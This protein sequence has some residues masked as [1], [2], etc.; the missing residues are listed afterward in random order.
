[1]TSANGDYAFSIEQSLLPS[2]FCI[3]QQNL[4][5]YIS[6]S[7]DSITVA[8]TSATSY[9]NNNFADVKLNV[10]LTEDGQHTITAGE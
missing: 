9:P 4:P 6:V 7:A 1:M 3:V 5:E 10:L 8:N 2:S